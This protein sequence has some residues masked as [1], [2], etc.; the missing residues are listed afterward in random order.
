MA[1]EDNMPMVFVIPLLTPL[2]THDVTP[3]PEAMVAHARS[4]LVHIRA[5][6]QQPKLTPEERLRRIVNLD[7]MKQS[8]YDAVLI[9][10]SVFPRCTMRTDFLVQVADREVILQS[11]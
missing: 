11:P 7:A 9:I 2:F 1:T 3:D 5:I 6:Q 8:L 4:R 10:R